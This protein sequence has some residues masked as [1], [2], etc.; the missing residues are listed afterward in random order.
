MN[1]L[2]Q[3]I[4]ITRQ[5]AERLKADPDLA[6]RLDNQ[7]DAMPILVPPSISIIVLA[8]ALA[9][10]GLEMHATDSGAIE[11]RHADLTREEALALNRRNARDSIHFTPANGLCGTCGADVVEQYGIPAIASGLNVTGCR[12]CH[13]SYCD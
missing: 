8:K 4:A 10:H 3:A 2:D 13:R 7:F 12:K 11:I 9:S 1:L 6:R 5:H